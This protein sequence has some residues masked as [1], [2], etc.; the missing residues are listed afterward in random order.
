MQRTPT[1]WRERRGAG[2]TL[3]AGIAPRTGIARLAVA[4][5]V[6]TGAASQYFVRQSE[7]QG[8][9][10]STRL[11]LAE[12]DQ[13]QR[14]GIRPPC[15]I[16]GSATPVAYYLGCSIGNDHPT[17]LMPPAAPSRRSEWRPLR[18]AGAAGVT[19]YIR[20]HQPHSPPLCR[21]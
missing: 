12:A 20:C 4:A 8:A 10:L 7:L 2:P 6:V 18:L 14:Q 1:T 17:V 16:A 19:A 3:H 13:L 15:E 11:Y 21:Q 9:E 5:F